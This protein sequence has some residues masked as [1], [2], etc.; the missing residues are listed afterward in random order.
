MDLPIRNSKYAFWIYKS[1]IKKKSFQIHQS[2]IEIKLP[3]LAI[4][5]STNYANLTSRT[6]PHPER[7]MIH[8]RIDEFVAH[9]QLPI[10]NKRWRSVSRFIELWEYRKKNI[11]V[12]EEKCRGARRNYLFVRR[13]SMSIMFLNQQLLLASYN[14][15]Q[16]QYKKKKVSLNKMGYIDFFSLTNFCITDIFSRMGFWFFVSRYLFVE[17]NNFF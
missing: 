12:Q 9:S 15:I 17:H 11:G 4:W 14:C 7:N 6:P 3:N 2:V 8:F 16:F 1:I 5:K 13:V 10:S